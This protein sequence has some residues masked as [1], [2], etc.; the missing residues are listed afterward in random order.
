MPIRYPLAAIHYRNLSDLARVSGYPLRTINRWKTSGIPR[1]SA[2]RL[3]IRL[4]LHPA[5]IWITWYA[6]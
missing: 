1:Y 3:A 4:G 6:D 2:D 5:N